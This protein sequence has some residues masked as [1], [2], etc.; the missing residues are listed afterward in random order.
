M[1]ALAF[2]VLIIGGGEAGLRAALAARDI[3][4]PDRRV[5]VAIKG[6][7]KQTRVM[8]A[9]GIEQMA[10]D[11]HTSQGRVPAEDLIFQI[12]QKN[13]TI[14]EDCMLLDLIVENGRCRGALCL[15]GQLGSEDAT[16]IAAGA[17]VL[18][19]DGA[20]TVYFHHL[21][22]LEETGDGYAAAWRAG[23]ELV[24]MEFMEIGLS[25][26]TLKMACTENVLRCIPRFI[27]S[28]HEDFLSQYFPP[29]WT[30]T[31]IYA[32]VFR[33]SE[34]W[35]LAW[36]NYAYAVDVAVYKETQTN[37]PVYLDFHRNPEGL[38]LTALPFDVQK[39]YEE[40]LKGE[41]AGEAYLVSPAQR[42]QILDPSCVGWLKKHGIDIMAGDLLEVV[43]AVR[44]IQ[45]G[46]RIDEQ[47]ATKVPGLFAVG[48]VTEQLVSY[49]S[50]DPI[51]PTT[52]DL[53]EVVGETAAQYA[54]SLKP[55]VELLDLSEM[56]ARWHLISIDNVR[57][58]AGA[59]ESIR[60][61]IQQIMY[62]EAAVVRTETGLRTA[63]EKIR[64]LKCSLTAP[65]DSGLVY[66]AETINMADVSIAIL[67]A[68]LLR[69][70]SWRSH[71][72]FPDGTAAEPIPPN[73]IKWHNYTAL[74][75]RNGE[76]EAEIRTVIR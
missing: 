69:E 4:P 29:G 21:S 32:A 36:E 5:A 72:R 2:D 11:A 60:Q 8:A 30:W 39:Y 71:L 64:T 59:V 40:A 34:A 62:Q 12:R 66:W 19:V 63:L 37:G 25:F 67:T 23:A 20:G 13:I 1:Q 46:I 58:A 42:L 14:I 55:E 38:D 16:V 43:P 74:S 56:V 53:S 17:V 70:E 31:D 54:V 24:D 41:A 75:L 68:A 22:P 6:K 35:P 18:T 48:I 26:P 52:K 10:T 49:H 7:L 15:V 76:I 61:Q 65:D 45:G 27:N 3:L 28:R 9:V 44:R 33:K 50:E 47:G 51:L 57:Q 73:E